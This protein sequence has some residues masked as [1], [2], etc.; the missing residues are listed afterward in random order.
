MV[1][2]FMVVCQEVVLSHSNMLVVQFLFFP[3]QIKKQGRVINYTTRQT[4]VAKIKYLIKK[5]THTH[6]P[7]E[8]ERRPTDR[9][10]FVTLNF[11]FIVYGT[12]FV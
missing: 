6:T 4:L 9:E 11:R 8:P 10:I 5:N 1:V 12:C 3:D 7:D 2:L